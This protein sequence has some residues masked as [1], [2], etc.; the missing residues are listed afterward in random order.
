MLN[1]E[2]CKKLKEAGFE[3]KKENCFLWVLEAHYD[4]NIQGDNEYTIKPDAVPEIIYSEECDHEEYGGFHEVLCYCP[5]LSELIKEC[6]DK[7]INLTRFGGGSDYGCNIKETCIG[8]D[9]WS[10]FN[11]TGK[12]PEEAVAN[13]WLKLNTK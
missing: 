13:L 7:F 5:T 9:G 10:E 8:I 11:S 1:Y 12:T 4:I 2:I 3:Q 6:G